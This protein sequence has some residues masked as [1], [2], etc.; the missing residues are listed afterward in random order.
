MDT[1]VEDAVY[2]HSHGCVDQTHAPKD[3]PLQIVVYYIIGVCVP[4]CPSQPFQNQI[5]KEKVV[6]LLLLLYKYIRL[7][8]TKKK[9]NLKLFYNIHY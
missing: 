2:D 4:E 6:S 7:A 5:L 3:C 1:R 8:N 9:L